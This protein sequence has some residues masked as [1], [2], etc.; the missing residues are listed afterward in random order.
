VANVL[1]IPNFFPAHTQ[2]ARNKFRILFIKTNTTI[3][4]TSVF[5]RLDCGY[6]TGEVD[7]RIKNAMASA[8]K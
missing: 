7:A 6:L 1:R 4:Y 2:G 8:S 5:L 3:P